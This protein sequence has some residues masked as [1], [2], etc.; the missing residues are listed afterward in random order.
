MLKN[1]VNCYRYLLFE[2]RLIDEAQS[3]RQQYIEELTRTLE[4]DKGSGAED[5][6]GNAGTQNGTD[7][8]CDHG[9]NSTD[10]G[11]TEIMLKV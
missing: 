7:E 1:T 3:L 11:E 4:M 10:E 6:E 9:S 8:Y 5:H 2:D